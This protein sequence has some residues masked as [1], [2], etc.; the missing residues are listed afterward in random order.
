M[1]ERN[2]ELPRMHHLHF[3]L[4][5]I[6][7]KKR[8]FHFQDEVSSFEE[9]LRVAYHFGSGFSILFVVIKRF[10]S[11]TGFH[12]HGHAVLNKFLH[13]FGGS[14]HTSFSR[15]NFFRNPYDHN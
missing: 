2:Q 6:F 8:F 12:K 14:S 9:V 5:H 10:Y 3:V 11:G 4:A 1:D 7:V 13:G 15:H